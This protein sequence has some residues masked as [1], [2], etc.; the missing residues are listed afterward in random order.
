MR[1]RLQRA[2]KRLAPNGRTPESDA[3]A[4]ALDAALVRLMNGEVTTA[5]LALDSAVPDELQPLIE[6]ASVVQ[7]LAPALTTE[8]RPQQR[9]SWRSDPRWPRNWRP[10]E[11]RQQCG[12]WAWPRRRPP[13]WWHWR[14]VGPW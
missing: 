14:A 8:A 2:A 5:A 12:R 7:S 3:L 10:S 11:A 6:L 9:S 13:P 1:A 4:A